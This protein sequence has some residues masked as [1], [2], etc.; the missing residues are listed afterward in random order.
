MFLTKENG[1]SKA[2]R[3]TSILSVAMGLAVSVAGWVAAQ[4]PTAPAE[5]LY[6]ES[7]MLD[8]FKTNGNSPPRNYRTSKVVKT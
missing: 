8:A 5:P 4:Q 1:M 3:R 7:T 2:T 6:L